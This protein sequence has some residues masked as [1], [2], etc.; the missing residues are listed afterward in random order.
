MELNLEH[1]GP[2]A[3]IAKAWPMR[4]NLNS[5]KCYG[6]GM[7]MPP[8]TGCP[9]RTEICKKCRKIPKVFN[10]ARVQ[11]HFHID[12]H[13]ERKQNVDRIRRAKRVSA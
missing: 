4:H 13:I 10:D 12:Q 5:V 2:Y 11:M 9:E 1:I 7:L 6:C 8:C 3:W